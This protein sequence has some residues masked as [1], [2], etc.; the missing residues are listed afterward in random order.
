MWFLI[1]SYDYHEDLF[2]SFNCYRGVF[3]ISVLHI[4]FHIF[5][6]HIQLH[7]FRCHIKLPQHVLLNCLIIFMNIVLKG[8]QELNYLLD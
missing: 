2:C 6:L 4:Q 8:C 7:T 5:R 3:D 1:F